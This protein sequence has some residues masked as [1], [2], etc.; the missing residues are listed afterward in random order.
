MTKKVARKLK[1][2]RGHREHRGEK[3]FPLFAPLRLCVLL[4]LH[5]SLIVISR[6][7]DEAHFG[8]AAAR[9]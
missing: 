2:H 4:V 3:I 1:N 6:F 9:V 7:F 5:N 8:R